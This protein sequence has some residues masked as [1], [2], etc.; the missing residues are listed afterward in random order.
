MTGQ[1]TMK[2]LDGTEYRGMFVEGEFHGQGSLRIADGT[3][4]QGFFSHC[5]R[6]GMF[7]VTSPSGQKR[8]AEF[9][10]DELVRWIEVAESGENRQEET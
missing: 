10:D 8:R 3:V 5:G 1:G 2:Y 9:A 7:V 4:Y 6:Q